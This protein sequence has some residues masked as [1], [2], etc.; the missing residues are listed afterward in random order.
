MVKKLIEKQK[1]KKNGLLYSDCEYCGKFMR[2]DNLKRRHIPTKH[3]KEKHNKPINN[4]LKENDVEDD[5]SKIVEQ[6]KEL[7]QQVLEQKKKYE[8]T[9]IG[10]DITIKRLNDAIMEKEGAIQR[11]KEELNA[12]K[13]YAQIHNSQNSY[14]KEQS[15]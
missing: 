5:T 1:Q 9:I 12:I 15:I 13:S 11:L 7:Y 10:K 8:E 3:S 4:E 14:N 6:Y 2:N